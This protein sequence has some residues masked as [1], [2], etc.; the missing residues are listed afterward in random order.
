MD[1]AT[2]IKSII[3]SRHPL[4]SKAAVGLRA[5]NTSVVKAIEEQGAL[6][7]ECLATTEGVDL[8]NEV[9]VA[10]GGDL[11]YINANK[12]VF[13]DH[14][15]GLGSTT[16]VLRWMKAV[17][18]TGTRAAGW[19]MRVRLLKA[20]PHY[21]MISEL[22]GLDTIGASIGIEAIDVGPPTELETKA[23][24]KASSVIRKWRAL[25]VSFT[26]LPMNVECQ[27]SAVYRSEATKAAQRRLCYAVSAGK[28]SETFA[29]RRAIFVVPTLN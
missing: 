9:V 5:F 13:A 8:D 14:E 1:T 23:Y 21:A 25:E 16:G 27:S 24:P 2:H 29:P 11:A 15:Y 20:S 12:K 3:R 28:L 6:E 18:A 7:I 17:P 19:K 22:A 4:S 26:A 10:S